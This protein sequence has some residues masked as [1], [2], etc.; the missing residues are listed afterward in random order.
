MKKPTVFLIMLISMAVLANQNS[1]TIAVYVSGDVLE[2]EKKVVGTI[3]LTSLVNSGRYKGIERS[4]AFIAEIDREQVKQRSG[5]I[6]DSQIRELGKQFGV[7][8]I[9]I[10]D[11]TRAFN[12]HQIS[13]R[14][15]DVE[16]AEVIRIAE[17]SIRGPRDGLEIMNAAQ[18]LAGELVGEN[19]QTR[20][21][22]QKKEGYPPKNERG[23]IVFTYNR[24]DEAFEMEIG[25]GI[26]FAN[27]FGG[28][29]EISSIYTE[30]GRRYDHDLKLPYSGLGVYVFWGWKYMIMPAQHE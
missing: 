1:P 3:M 15:V 24:G 27:D 22:K 7:K 28:G 25:V 18:Q 8:Y 13:T 26:C 23:D 9:C 17:T 10:A 19:K 16:T 4:A 2:N 14:I 11:I 5:A 29:R 20:P 6:D 21:Q 12:V 30:T